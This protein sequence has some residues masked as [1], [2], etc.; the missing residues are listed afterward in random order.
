MGAKKKVKKKAGNFIE[1]SA[2]IYKPS[3]NVS[4]KELNVFVDDFTELVEKYSMYYHGSI[5]L[6]KVRN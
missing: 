2:I 5:G 6:K 3:D 1:V 4:T